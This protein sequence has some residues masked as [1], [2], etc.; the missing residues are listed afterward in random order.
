MYTGVFIS[1]SG[2]KGMQEM[3]NATLYILF[4]DVCLLVSAN[5]FAIAVFNIFQHYSLLDGLLLYTSLW[6]GEAGYLGVSIPA[7][8]PGKFICSHYTLCMLTYICMFS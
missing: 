1:F 4:S 7:S 8:L 2:M 3:K 6:V 5:L